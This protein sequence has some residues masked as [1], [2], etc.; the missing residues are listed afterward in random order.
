MGLGCMAFV[1][2]PSVSS[3][4]STLQK[5]HGVV[6]LESTLYTEDLSTLNESWQEEVSID[7]K[8]SRMKAWATLP[9]AQWFSTLLIGRLHTAAPDVV[10]LDH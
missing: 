2:C 5:E 8:C 1:C 9:S 3:E 6:R 10:T 7:T 4:E